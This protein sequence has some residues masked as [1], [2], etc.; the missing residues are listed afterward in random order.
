MPVLTSIADA[1]EG[2]IR[3]ARDTLFEEEL[4][5]ELNREAR[6]ALKHGV[7]IRRNLVQFPA[8]D[9]R[10]VLIDLVGEEDEDTENGQSESSPAGS[11]DDGLAYFVAQSFRMLLSHAHR[12]NLHRRSQIPPPIT[13]KKRPTPEYVLFRPSF[14]YLQHRSH[15][16]WLADLVAS[17]SKTLHSAG[18]KCSPNTFPLTSVR[19][20]PADDASVESFVDSL[21][22][23]LES[24]IT[25]RLCSP[26]YG[27]RVRIFTNMHPTGVGTTFELTTNLPSLAHAMKPPPKFGVRE[28]VEEFILHLYTLDLVHYV[29]TLSKRVYQSGPPATTTADPPA[30]ATQADDD[31]E[32]IDDDEDKEAGDPIG[33]L[34]GILPLP[35]PMS[36]KSAGL[37][38]MPLL[39]W[40]P[41]FPE[42]GEL[43][44]F[45][46]LKNRSRKLLLELDR[47][48]L[49]LRTRWIGPGSFLG[50][51]LGHVADEDTDKVDK[52][53]K[54]EDIYVWSAADG[55][56]GSVA[57][58]GK[59][60]LDEV[61]QALGKGDHEPGKM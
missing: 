40:E 29:S 39:P 52:A 30:A 41:A 45:S 54:V 55:R 59:P 36:A 6:V 22:N 16:L 17:I 4:F 58:S 9:D 53:A 51:D 38:D 12:K 2:Q 8:D 5:Y 47:A 13:Q 48:Q 33:L 56:E 46:P 37:K 21:I 49:V 15:F 20:P 44:A 7:E 3:Q 57:K 10:D 27:F 28:Q 19:F 50:I 43:A 26:S 11:E 14:C 1:V 60:S 42:R 61:I 35:L 34:T 24:Y 18:F 25:M 31:W 32:D 23:P